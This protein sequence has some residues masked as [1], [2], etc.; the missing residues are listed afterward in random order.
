M[1][2]PY[3]KKMYDAQKVNTKLKDHIPIEKEE[4]EDDG[5]QKSNSRD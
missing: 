1:A 5:K 3:S 2:K 4:K